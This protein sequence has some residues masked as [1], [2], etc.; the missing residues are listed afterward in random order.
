MLSF[1]FI[2]IICG[3][4]NER[5]DQIETNIQKLDTRVKQ[6]EDKQQLTTDSK[7]QYND[8]Y[9]K[10]NTLKRWL[11]VCLCCCVFI[12]SIFVLYALSWIGTCLSTISC[13][14]CDKYDDITRTDIEIQTI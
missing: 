1:L 3:Q 9:N 5:L 6:L 14:C 11:I 4:T 10:Y 2:R 12:L 7:Q 13:T 8:L